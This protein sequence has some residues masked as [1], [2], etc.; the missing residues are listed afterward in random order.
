MDQSCWWEVSPILSKGS[1]DCHV[2]LGFGLCGIP[3]NLIEALRDLGAKELTV[4]SNNAG[5]VCTCTC[6]FA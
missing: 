3:E 5:Y 4:V 1:R 2:I 6:T